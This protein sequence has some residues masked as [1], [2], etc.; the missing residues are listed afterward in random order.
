MM[1]NVTV[2]YVSVY[3][4]QLPVNKVV[5]VLNAAEG[6]FQS[7]TASMDAVPNASAERM[8]MNV[9]IA[10]AQKNVLTTRSQLDILSQL[11]SGNLRFTVTVFLLK[12]QSLKVP[13]STNIEAMSEGKLRAEERQLRTLL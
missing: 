2:A 1:G 6:D 12:S 3:K 5:G 7:A 9:C 11:Q 4:H 8:L 13:I 10:I